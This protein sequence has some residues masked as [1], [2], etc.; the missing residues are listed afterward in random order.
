RSSDLLPTDAFAFHGFLP[1]KSGARAN[2]LKKHADS[3]V[4]LV[5]YESP[6][7]L[8][9]TLAAMAEA[10]GDRQAVV[11]LELTKRFERSFRG[12]LSA[13]AARSEREQTKAEAA[14]AAASAAAPG[15]TP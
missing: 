5:F 8:A 6:R 4:T 13:L 14:N 1:P 15:R 3:R 11:A 12:T 9:D 7:R 2:A 10:L